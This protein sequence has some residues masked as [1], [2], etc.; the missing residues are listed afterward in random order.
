MMESLKWKCT[1]IGSHNIMSVTFDD[2]EVEIA[3]NED[4]ATKLQNILN[5]SK[6][7]YRTLSIENDKLHKELA[8]SVIAPEIK[9]TMTKWRDQLNNFLDSDVSDYKADDAFDSSD[10]FFDREF[11]CDYVSSEKSLVN[12]CRAYKI[13]GCTIDDM[14]EQKLIPVDVHYL[15]SKYGLSWTN[16]AT[17][18]DSFFIA[19]CDDPIFDKKKINQSEQKK[20]YDSIIELGPK[21]ENLTGVSSIDYIANCLDVSVGYVWAY[22]VAAGIDFFA[23][24]SF[25]KTSDSYHVIAKPKVCLEDVHFDVLSKDE[26]FA[27]L[28]GIGGVPFL[29]HCKAIG[30][31]QT[32]IAGKYHLRQHYISKYIVNHKELWS[33]W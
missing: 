30:M 28:D 18:S 19:Y 23:Y 24:N 3:M 4:E 25:S 6:H 27:L 10:V 22:C 12:L 8:G 26:T 31:S 16:L 33:D 5:A 9:K 1:Q 13:L 2:V 32:D 29:K 15:L 20:I 17:K 7:A 21:I 11:D 14:R